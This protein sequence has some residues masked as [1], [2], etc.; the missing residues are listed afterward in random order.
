[1]I[2]R[3]RSAPLRTIW[4]ALAAGLIGVLIAIVPAHAERTL[5]RLEDF[6]LP[7]GDYRTLRSV[8]LGECES[9]CLADPS[10]AAFTYND[11]ATWCFLKNA[12]GERVPYAGATSAI[13]RDSAS[14]PT[15]PL[16]ELAFL[17]A[18]IATDAARLEAQLSAARRTDRDV[19]LVTPAQAD[20]VAANTTRAWLTLSGTLLDGQYSD[21][22]DRREAERLAGA[23]GYLG[24]EAATTPSEQGWALAAISAALERQGLYRPA[25]EASAAS[26][27]LDLDA[28]ERDRLARLRAEHGFR[29]LDYS[30][31][32]DTTSPRLCVQ[33]SELLAGEAGD[34]ER[35]V[36]VD[37]IA[38]PTLSVDDSQICV[39][40]LEHGARYVLTVRSGLPSTVGETLARDA[41]FRAY[42][43][44]RAP[45]A[46][47]ETNRYVLPASAQGIPVTTVN[48]KELD[49][50]LHRINDRN[51]AE[52][53]R[54][55]DFKRQLYPYEVDELAEERGALAWSGTMAVDGALNEDTVTLFPVDSVIRRAE[56]GV[57]VLT[58]VPTELADR[59]DQSA[60]QWFVVSDIG[61]S[62]YSAAG[63]VDVFAR[64]LLSAEPSQGVEVALLARN[65]EVLAT[66]TTDGQG[67]ARLVS[68]APTTGSEAPAVVTA[69]AGEDYAFLP[70]LGG[71][72]ELTD[73]GVAGRTAPGPVDA[74]LATERGV[75]RGGETVHLTAL[76]RDDTA[77]ALPLPV[78][79]RLVRPD[80]VT[81]RSLTARADAAGGVALE[82]PL[83]GNA[84][85][86][87]WT[88]S[89]HIDPEGPA[90]GT[91]TFLVEDYVPQRIA[92][93]LSSEA[94][95]ARAGEQIDAKVAAKFLYG[96]PAA[97]LMMEGTVTV[98]PADEVAGFEG[99]S[100]GLVEEPFAAQRAPLFDLPRTG[101]DGTAAITVP[102]PDL[103]DAQ[104]A[105]EAR[106]VVSVREPG[107]R[108]VADTLTLPV[109]TASPMIGIRQTFDDGRVAEGSRA[110]FDVLALSPERQRVPASTRWTL[111]RITRNFQW[112]RRNGQ[113][114]YD[115]VDRLEEV[116]SGAVDIDGGPP[117]SVSVPVAWGRYRLEVVDAANERIASSTE[118]D[119]GWLSSTTTA[120][121]P[122]I[123]EIHLD[124]ESYA[125]GETATLRIVPRYAGQALVTVLSGS[126]RHHELVD[127]PLTGAE[128]AIA[129]EADWAPGAYVAATLFRPVERATGGQPLP[130][131]AVG[132]AHMAI[133]TEARRLA[134]AID[135]PETTTP[136]QSLTV[137]VRVEG[138]APGE[139]AH[140]TVAAVD[141]GILNV[142]GFEPPDADRYYLGQRRLAVELRDLYGDLIDS[143]GASRGRIRS[144]GDGP[145]AGT[146]ALP[147]NEAPV[148]L[149]TGVIATEAG[150]IARARFDIPSFNGTL[151]L[152]A[153]AWT[154][155]KVGDASRDMVV[156]DPVVVSGTLPRF[157]A[158]GD[159]SRMRIDLHNVAAEPG[160]YTLSVTA[161]GPVILDRQEDKL[162]LEADQRAAIELP[163]AATGAGEARLIATLKGPDGLSIAK[164]YTVTVR[165]AASEV[166]DRRVVVLSPGEER[167]LSVGL[168]DG[169]DSDAALTLS[170]GQG[171][172]DTAGLLAMLD[173]FPYGC[174]EQTVSQALP[175]LYA[176]DLSRTVGLD[177]DIDVPKRV[178]KAIDRVLAFQ[179]SS[180]GFALWSPGYDLWLTAYVMD[181][182]SRAREQSYAVPAQ[183]FESG[184]DRLQSVLSYTGDVEGERGTD[185][186]YA[187]YVLA[188]NGRAAIGDVRYFA[189]E[190]LEDFEAPLAR[191]QLAASLAF[192]GDGLL[193]ERLFARSVAAN[194]DLA[195][196][197]RTDY[198]TALR[199][200]AAVVALAGEA[201]ISRPVIDDLSVRLD[202]I[203]AGVTRSYST[204]EAAWL[205]LSA[206]ATSREDRAATVDGAAVDTPFARALDRAA[207]EAGVTV[208]NED[209]EPI[210]I[211]T[212]VAG[213]PL[214]PQPP[215]S[216]GL[217]IERTFHTP[218]DG[219]AVS[220]DRV[221]QN[222]RLLVR[223]TLAKTVADPM[224]LMLTDLLPA[225]FEIENPRLV[226]GGDVAAL[227]QSAQG[228]SPEHTEFRDDR[229]AAA[230]TL[231]RGNENAPISVSYMVRA[232]SPGTFAL[233]PSEVS[234]MYQPQFVARTAQGTV[235]VVPTR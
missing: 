73:R 135:A 137:P 21:D 51:L 6:D 227:P 97:D 209:T 37:T 228:Q 143:D 132:I 167:T 192:N 202:A 18:S 121:T 188:R 162:R 28:A 27:S 110:T 65:D 5:E 151:K 179:S 13:V 82:M 16:P 48:T 168:L 131:R 172:L 42:V 115:S 41:E 109:A 176:N 186:A 182:L 211:A 77:R 197:E 4:T 55:G 187:T 117:G 163:I 223:I 8:T 125:A 7:G 19:S 189:E 212:T 24:L 195:R 139:T 61:L 69:R 198:G 60:T 229:F 40:G 174:A 104:G 29:V 181:F 165:P 67:Y 12:A 232:I 116:A 219:E 222:T 50:A 102:L 171:D 203:R 57:Y 66:G 85:T 150:G 101:P 126:V 118:F 114:A 43:R 208:R 216:A 204:Q 62:T 112:Y 194:L 166:R 92:V 205:L 231:G 145:G 142:T 86:G 100:F 76:V 14:A 32:S 64:S 207:L 2:L 235:T 45:L 146:E 155:G 3:P 200:A 122:D 175:L 157:L 71:A 23:A 9:S 53:V 220:P 183:A 94:D 56:P 221:A 164:D 91:T 103:A 10:C 22:R 93:D 98:Q 215:V 124:K 234:D 169:Y 177:R 224:R 20:A 119:A 170:V 230:W 58:A 59:S 106:I 96:A 95:E 75:Y 79:I 1:M 153:I 31:D 156:R 127:V 49:L 206:N 161:D 193:A 54:R 111:T 26:V 80:G 52:V 120:D 173:R 133:D 130:Q 83:T 201:R 46:R 217:T 214:A 185:V 180:G 47:F 136:R 226:E 233:P 149:F 89:A 105:L 87:T 178:R 33:F 141:V 147:L 30:V 225:G 140:L 88:V 35:F 154:E 15:L 39:E 78:T 44:D 70:L 138:L 144:G 74:F 38:A 123:P 213:T 113:W 191:A 196:P 107:G 63:T 17:P 152:M 199:D 128:I 158:P 84:A 159:A 34:L 190:R 25:I 72:F 108:V 36:A 134:V 81:S 129:V 148:S 90:V 184:L 160:D 99:Y 210:A 218:L 11:R 68:S